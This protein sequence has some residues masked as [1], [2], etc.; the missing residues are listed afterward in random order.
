[1]K[2]EIQI[3]NPLDYGGW[4]DLIISKPEYSFF[5]SS[6]WAKVLND[7]YGYI[8]RYL[9][10][11][12]GQHIQFFL[13]IMEINS[14]LTGKRGISL[15]FTDY[16]SPLIDK[17]C[18]ISWDCLIE[19][20]RN[21]QWQYIEIR[22]DLLESNDIQS[23]VSYYRHIIE[24]NSIQEMEN[25]IHNNHKRNMRK[26][27]SEKITI[28]F[29]QSY[30]ALKIYYRLHCLTRKRHGLPPQ[31]WYFFQS[32]YK[33]IIAPGQGGIV[34]GFY[35]SKP[36]T[37]I[38]YFQYCKNI[39]Y[40]YGGLDQRYQ[41]LGVNYILWREVFKKFFELGFKTIDFGRTSLDN[42]GLR[43]F[44]LGWGTK[45]QLISYY[46]YS[47]IKDKFITE[48]IG[49]FSIYKKVLQRTPI[50]ISKQI[51]QMLYKHMA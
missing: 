33:Y 19:F 7:S 14:Y 13:P 29:L 22:G 49:K 28:D 32:I 48:S 37:G 4:D 44:K 10:I 36:V 30:E 12:N 46:R 15:P 41:S 31:P 47:Y 25:K 6:A 17:S 38:I 1:M 8:P 27:K 16:C 18:Q 23:S 20:C 42:Q 5:H 50:F 35:D 43:R 3:I 11:I 2:H 26:A 24:L 51:G 9:S 40:K 45:E 34:L 21:F 39:I